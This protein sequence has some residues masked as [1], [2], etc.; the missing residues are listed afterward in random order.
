MQFLNVDAVVFPFPAS[1]IEVTISLEAEDRVP[2]RGV[3]LCVDLGE[4]V[5]GVPWSDAFGCNYVYLPSIEAGSSDVSVAL[6]LDEPRSQVALTLQP[7]GN[8]KSPTPRVSSAVLSAEGTMGE[9][10]RKYRVS[11]TVP[12]DFVGQP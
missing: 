6:A 7:W 3:L 12:G 11:F 5:S 9:E 2:D 1:E 8:S 10:M 4:R